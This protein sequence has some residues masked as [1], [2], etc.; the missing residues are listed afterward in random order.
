M[1]YKDRIESVTNNDL[2]KSLSY[3]NMLWLCSPDKF[4]L[5]DKNSKDKISST[6]AINR[7]NPNKICNF[8]IHYETSNR[9]GRRSGHWCAMS[10]KGN[11]VYFFDSLG[12]F[13]DDELKKI[14]S[15][16]RLISGQQERDIGKILYNLSCRNYKINYN[17]IKFQQDSPDISTC[18]RFCA[19]FFSIVRSTNTDPYRNMK[20]LL[21]L[22][23]KK[24][25]DYLD[26]S[27][28]RWCKDIKKY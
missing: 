22:Y 26:E 27:V 13:P 11:N 28:V 21:N 10:V 24:G 6:V 5:I 19:C 9:D 25:E 20:N 12:L 18:G 7:L 1:Q 16:Y 8:L 15:Y 2:G 4:T 3:A 23:R 17:D 14:S